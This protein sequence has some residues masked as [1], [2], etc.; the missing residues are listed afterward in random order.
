VTAVEPRSAQSRRQ[1]DWRTPRAEALVIFGATGDLARRKIFPALYRME[2]RDALGVPV[3]GV[4]RA[5]DDEDAFRRRVRDAVTTFVPQHDAAVVDR[6]VG[7]VHLVGGRYEEASTFSALATVL[8]RLGS[9]LSVFYLA[10]P[11]DLFATVADGLARAGL[12]HRARLVVEKPFGRDLASARRLSAMLHTHVPEAS[13]FRIDHFLG[14]ETVEDLMV[15]RFANSILEPVWNRNYVDS[16]QITMAE[17]LGMEGRGAFYDE[18]GAVRDVLQNHL[19]EVVSLLAMEPP[20][21]A[22]AAGLLD[23]KVKVLRA[24]RPLDCTTLIR[25]Q[26]RGYHEER[27]VE[28][29]STTETFAACRLEID[30][31]RWAGVPFFVRAGKRLPGTAL[32][33]VVAMRRPPRLLFADGSD[34]QPQGNLVRFRLSPDDGVTLTMH[35]KRPGRALVSRTVD[36]DVDYREEPGERQEAYERLL[37]DA[38]DGERRRFARQDWVEQAWRVVQPALDEPGPVH[39]YEPETWGPVE[40]DTILEGH[41]W[42][43][44]EHLA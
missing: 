34:D 11:P 40:A 13:I 17:S 29:G 39:P 30:S 41:R 23:E 32:E 43:V 33:A 44:P 5:E 1:G 31:W 18:I 3:V 24:M 28:E 6:L 15:F 37:A 7:R 42:H 12:S 25:G 8:D 38:L 10:I 2:S 26:Y 22:D 20:V 35:A 9:E 27:G 4:A 36:L 19:L 21:Q 14:K 16:V